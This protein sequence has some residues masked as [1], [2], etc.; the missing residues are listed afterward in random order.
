MSNIPLMT[1]V[2]ADPYNKERTRAISEVWGDLSIYLRPENAPPRLRPAAVIRV[3]VEWEEEEE[4]EDGVM[5]GIAY[6]IERVR[7]Y[8]MEVFEDEAMAEEWLH[9]PNPALDNQRPLALAES[10]EGEKRVMVTL[11]RIEHGVFS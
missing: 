6:R 4:K 9:C 5:G 3:T 8:A 2:I 7:A 10:E 11:G 1:W